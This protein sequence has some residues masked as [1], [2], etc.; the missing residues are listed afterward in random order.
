VTTSS[1]TLPR[2]SVEPAPTSDVA[3]R[4]A[5]L[6]QAL[7]PFVAEDRAASWRHLVVALAVLVLA[8]AA[9]WLVPATLWPLKIALGIV[10]GFTLMRPFIIFHDHLHGAMFHDSRVAS[11]IL[12]GVGMFMLTPRGIWRATHN[13][14]HKHNGRMSNV[15]I[16]TLPVVSVATW[17]KMSALDRFGY[18]ALRHPLFIF[19][20]YVTF[21]LIGLSLLPFFTKSPADGRRHYGGLFAV[22]L[23]LGLIALVVALSG[24]LDAFAVVILPLIVAHGVGS[25]LFYAQH[26]FPEM[27]LHS[28]GANPD[29]TDAALRGSSLFVMSRFMHWV[30]GNIGF[31]HVHHLNH[32]IP[33]YRLPEAMAAVPE[34]QS[35][36]RTSW[37]PR[38]IAANLR[39]S[40]WS[41]ELGRMLT[42]RELRA[43]PQ[44]A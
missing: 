14:H 21:F 32:R 30:T 6:N 28:D 43:L 5:A 3:R 34:L 9:T 26:N 4:G 12:T 33:F 22:A 41:D 35:P 7:R 25:Y 29:Y 17:R 40:V 42:W 27:V 1:A 15:A 39:L 2:A 37:R 10:A 20:A 38:D 44:P 18:R 24:W 11:A 31:H 13:H 8:L 16:G 23:H 19:P 36:G